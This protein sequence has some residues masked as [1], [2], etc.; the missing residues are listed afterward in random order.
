VLV[1]TDDV[2][3]ELTGAAEDSVGVVREADG[4]V[5]LFDGLEDLD[6]VLD[7]EAASGGQPVPFRD[8]YV[9]VERTFGQ[10]RSL[11]RLPPPEGM[12]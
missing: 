7:L 1:Q 5:A 9:G 8:G 6:E 12:G 11:A 10:L 2:V 3:E 4:E